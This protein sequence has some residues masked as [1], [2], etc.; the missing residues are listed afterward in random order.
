MLLS[1]NPKSF[2]AILYFE[3]KKHLTV[4]GYIG[5][6][7]KTGSITNMMNVATVTPKK[8]K[9]GILAYEENDEWYDPKR[10]AIINNW[11]AKRVDLTEMDEPEE[12]KDLVLGD[13]FLSVL[14]KYELDPNAKMQEEHKAT[15][16]ERRARGKAEEDWQNLLP[17]E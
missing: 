15:E 14:S 1:L 17:E 2:G 4:H 13:T 5:E 11:D 16:E 7:P 3:T 12:L 8:D 6:N 9:G 10:K